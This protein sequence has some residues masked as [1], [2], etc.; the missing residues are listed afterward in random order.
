MER[1]GY[2]PAV[3]DADQPHFFYYRPGE[4]HALRRRYRRQTLALLIYMIVVVA[5]IR[6]ILDHF[7]GF[8]KLAFIKPYILPAII[9]LALIGWVS[10]ILVIFR[11]DNMRA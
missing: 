11:K 1:R 6:L 3:T 5:P 8:A 4:V 10:G 7:A 9:A 2:E